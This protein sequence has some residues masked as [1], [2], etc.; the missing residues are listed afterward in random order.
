[1]QLIWCAGY[2]WLA[3][4]L[5]CIFLIV[6]LVAAVAETRALIRA[7]R[8]AAKKA[9]DAVASANRKGLAAGAVDPVKL[10]EALKGVLEALK[11]LPA[12]IAVFL[13]GLALLWI[14]A[15][16]PEACAPSCP[17]RKCA[18]SGAQSQRDVGRQGTGSSNTNT[19]AGGT[20]TK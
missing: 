5:A 20:A 9:P 17:D 3:F 13:A 12:W 1:M 4:L 16:Q 11:G 7:K 2:A 19:S 18:S 10:L 6:A 15:R 8:E 14:A